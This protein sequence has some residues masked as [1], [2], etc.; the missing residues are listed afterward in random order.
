MR[1]DTL[2]DIAK[3]KLSSPH[4]HQLF[5]NRLAKILLTFFVITIILWFLYSED[6]LSFSIF[7]GAV[8]GFL[9]FAGIVTLKRFVRLT[10]GKNPQTNI[11][12]EKTKNPTERIGDKISDSKIL[13]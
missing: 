3:G 7:G 5:F 12:L 6:F 1:D 13:D 8:L 11:W 10:L 9:V 2:E 4:I